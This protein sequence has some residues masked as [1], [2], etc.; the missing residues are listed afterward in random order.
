MKN[1]ATMV[2]CFAVSIMLF[3]G[4]EKDDPVIEPEGNGIAEIGKTYVSATANAEKVYTLQVM[5]CEIWQT[6]TLLRAM[7]MPTFILA[8]V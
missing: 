2:A 8:K 7:L 6:T 4:C 3:T 5:R 1:V